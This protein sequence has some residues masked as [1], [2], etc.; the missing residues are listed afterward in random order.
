MLVSKV[1][2]FSTTGSLNALAL[3]ADIDSRTRNPRS[4]SLPAERLTYENG[5]LIEVRSASW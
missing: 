1:K 5:C 3:A 4:Q 2:N